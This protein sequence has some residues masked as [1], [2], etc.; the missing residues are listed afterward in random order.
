MFRFYRV[1]R[2][3]AAGHSGFRHAVKVCEC[4]SFYLDSNRPKNNKIFPRYI[5]FNWLVTAASNLN[6]LIVLL[7]NR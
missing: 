2:M 5:N 6:H 1:G 4:H 7:I 3:E